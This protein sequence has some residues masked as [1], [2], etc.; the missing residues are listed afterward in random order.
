MASILFTFSKQSN[1][2]FATDDKGLKFLVASEVVYQGN[3]GLANMQVLNEQAY[4]A[5]GFEGTFG[6][7]AWFLYPTAMCESKGS[8][9]CLN[10][11]DRAAFTF[12]F[13][14]YACHVPNGDF[15]LF[16]RKLLQL[17]NAKDYFPFLELRD[18]R[19]WYS[20]DGNPQQL[21]NNTS[22]APL[23]NYLNPDKAAVDN[24]ELVS[25]AR[26][27]H[28]AQHHEAHR[29]L[30]VEVAVQHFKRKIREYDQRYNLDGWPDHICHVICDIHHQGRA[31]FSHV[32]DIMRSTTN[33]DT[34][35]RNLLNVGVE[36]Y[37]ERIITLKDAHKKMIAEGRFG[38]KVYDAASGEFRA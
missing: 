19:I 20:K 22:T 21:E 7:W 4:N 36:V 8:F 15:V 18:N 3:H 33:R 14:Q 1:K 34:I 30:Q 10:S 32:V 37:K 38:R 2:H 24:Q 23:M 27:V 29:K 11:Y 16:F 26:F 13:M 6:A 25:A 31:K 9:H 12:G 17:P 5:A 28:W 35:Y